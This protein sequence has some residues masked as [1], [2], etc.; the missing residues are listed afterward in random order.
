MNQDKLNAIVNWWA[1]AIENPKFDMGDNSLV[2]QMSESIASG[3]V[4]PVSLGEISSFR[5]YLSEQI[6]KSGVDVLSVDYHPCEALH[7]AMIHADIS[8]N[9]AP[10]KTSMVIEKD[11][12][13]VKYGYRASWEVVW[14]EGS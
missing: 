7:S 1:E 13:R 10:W 3:Q 8:L 14:S 2:G 6:S 4:K 5:L 11:L 9:N 12:V